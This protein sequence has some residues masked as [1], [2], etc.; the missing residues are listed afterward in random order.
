MPINQHSEVSNEQID[1]RK[2]WQLCSFFTF[3]IPPA[4]LPFCHF[5]F[6]SEIF[7]VREAKGAMAVCGGG[8]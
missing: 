4:T 3:R 2:R 1:G 7:D 6:Q 5:P 8:E